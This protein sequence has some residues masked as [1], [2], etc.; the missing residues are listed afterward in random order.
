MTI[1]V[2]GPLQSGGQLARKAVRWP[3]HMAWLARKTGNWP[4]QVAPDTRPVRRSPVKILTPD[5]LRLSEVRNEVGGVAEQ[6]FQ[7][8]GAELVQATSDVAA[9]VELSE[10]EAEAR[11]LAQE[12]RAESTWR[13]Y[14]SHTW[15]TRPRPQP[16]IAS[17]LWLG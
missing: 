9:L 17:R 12:S 1:D 7:T 16:G 15:G 11:K 6:D 4:D 8:G 14:G 3:T 13:A 10:L 2:Q 5:N